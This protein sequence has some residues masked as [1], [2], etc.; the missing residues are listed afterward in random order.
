MVDIDEILVA[1][2]RTASGGP[3]SRSHYHVEV[4]TSQVQ[5]CEGTSQAIAVLIGQLTQ[6]GS[7]RQ[8]YMFLAHCDRTRWAPVVYVSGVLGFWEAPIRKLGIPVVLLGGSPLAKVRQ[9]RAACIANDTKCFFSWSS[10]TNSYGLALIGSGIRRIGSYRNALFADLPTRGRWLWSWAGLVGISIVVCNSRE[11]QTQVAGRSGSGKQVLYVPNGVQVFAP[12]QVRAW[13]EQW[14]AR[15]GLGDDAVLV[16]G[17]G[18]LAPQKN[19][20]RFIDVIAQV[21]RQVPI[22]A[23]I[24]GA[25]EGCLGD[26]QDQVARLGLQEVIRFIGMV[27]DARELICA[28][29]IFMLSSDHEGM[30]NVVLE[31]V[32]A[33]VPCVATRVNSIDDMIEQGA[34]GF[35]AAHSIDDLAQHVARL[36]ADADLR[37]AMGSRARATIDSAYR[38]EQVARQLWA[39]AEGAFAETKMPRFKPTK[40]APFLVLLASGVLK[41]ATSETLD[42][43]GLEPIFREDFKHPR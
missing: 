9:F 6:G 17:A 1:A 32:A 23:V 13:R 34:T 20:A 19:F 15:L 29:D 24:A 25:D 2:I 41:D 14:R 16:L 4:E 5:P 43:C 39:V 35:V 31:A 11:T 12:E 7:E 3:G 40:L 26:L 22:Q 42:L 8:L 10:Y 37:R 33:G 27:P 18:R 21:C 38:P 36:A 30:P 28:A